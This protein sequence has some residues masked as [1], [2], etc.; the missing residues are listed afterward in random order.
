MV[1][2][3]S[4]HFRWQIGQLIKPLNPKTNWFHKAID[5]HARAWALKAKAP[6]GH[7]R[8]W[9]SGSK[10][11]RLP[12]AASRRARIGRGLRAAALLLCALPATWQDGSLAWVNLVN[13]ET[14]FAPTAGLASRSK[15]SRLS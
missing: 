11:L 5:G 2:A 1:R 12:D 7:V 9:A 3:V 8:T 14:H 10:L 13:Q 15:S 6:Q 4:P